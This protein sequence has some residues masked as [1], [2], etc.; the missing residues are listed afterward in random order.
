LRQQGDLTFG[1]SAKLN[2][3]WYVNNLPRYH[4]QGHEPSFGIPVHADKKIFDEPPVYTFEQPVRGTY[5]IW[6]DPAYWFEGI[7]THINLKG[8]IFQVIENS[9]VY[10][11]VLVRSQPL[12]LLAFVTLLL[13]SG[14][15]REFPRRLLREWILWVP[16]F[17]ALSMFA[18]VHVE[19]RMIGAYVVI[20]WLGL[21]AALA[22]PAGRVVASVATALACVVI[23]ALCISDLGDM[24][25]KGIAF[26]LRGDNSS[27]APHQ[28]A[29]GLGRLG[30]HP[31]DRVAWIRPQ[32]FDAKQNYYWARIANV[33]ISAEIPVGEGDK[34]WSAPEPVKEQALQAI[35]KTGVRA[36][37]ATSMPA[38]AVTDEWR[39]L[40]KTGY[41]TLM[42][43]SRAARA[44]VS[45]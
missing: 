19:T 10:Y 21:F 12:F 22:L 11:D 17:C 3:G 45:K 37:I 43:D 20:L 33:Q 27:S 18:L 24:K 34:L 29:A 32:P 14:S 4:W 38:G 5:P 15:A 6:K 30:I 13:W 8:N 31:G 26:L 28:I 2:Y 16:P 44:A 9:D 36:L 23:V 39:P 41:F 1:E 42:L 35:A 7:R 25:T 40:G